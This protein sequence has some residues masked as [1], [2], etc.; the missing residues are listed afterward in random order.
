MEK[1]KIWIGYV[2]AHRSRAVGDSTGRKNWSGHIV[3]GN[4]MLKIVLEGRMEGRR[5]W[6]EDGY[7]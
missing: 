1:R 2:L 3:R 7:H 4:G 6:T 5:T